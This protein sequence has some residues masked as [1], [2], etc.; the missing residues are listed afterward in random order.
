MIMGRR[1]LQ[2]QAACNASA[3]IDDSIK[4]FADF[5]KFLAHLWQFGLRIP[6]GYQNEAGFHFG[7]QPAPFEYLFEI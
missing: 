7:M 1:I 5:K 2:N 3:R 4:S 6:V